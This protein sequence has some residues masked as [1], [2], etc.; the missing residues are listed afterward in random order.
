MNRN[1]VNK[2]PVPGAAV[3]VDLARRD[4]LEK[5]VAGTATALAPALML[6]GTARAAGRIIKVGFVSPRTG[7]LAPFGEGDEYVIA[8]LKTMLV[9]GVVING[10]TYP[11]QIIAKD[12][13]SNP[14][15]AAE[16]A[17]SL[18]KSDKVDLM[19]AAS[20]ADTVNPVA[21]QCELNRVPMV[22]TDCPWQ[23]YYFG[24]GGKPDKGFEWT[25][26]FFWG[27]E[28][29]ISVFLNMWNS[30]PTNKVVGVLWPND[31][32]GNAFG[33]VKAGFPPALAKAGYQMI[34]GGRF[35]A[36]TADFTA[37]I[38]M[39]KRAGVEILSGALTPPAFAT[40]WTQA[41]QQ[42]FR[43]KIASVAK[44]LLFPAAVQSLGNRAIGLTTEVWWSPNH[45]YKSGLT[46]E[47]AGQFC[48]AWEAATNK[49]WTQPL[50]FRHALIEVAVDIF[51]RTANI[52]SREAIRDAI[53]T[54]NYQSIV[55]PIAWSGNPVKNVTKTPLVGGQWIAGKK[56]KH[57]LVIVNNDTEKTIPL[58]QK[59]ADLPQS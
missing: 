29:V 25:Y 18:I 37:Q 14:N 39:F 40:F 46:G 32:E 49:P 4:F 43:P 53:R 24:R 57:D 34:D 55:G 13:Q 26:H 10:A 7:P 6:P 54:T 35:P 11:I 5:A 8:A 31:A 41:A 3:P 2:T 21:D 42:G 12:S 51:K 50:G 36:N 1:Q 17:S 16:V 38:N 45:P 47:T 58:Q 22:S 52:D 15:R 44:G 33:D 48:A 23:P 59:V 28:D 19:L 9:R 56:F 20:T 27:L 30:V